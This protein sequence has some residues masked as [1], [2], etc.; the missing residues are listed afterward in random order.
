VKENV[1]CFLA[2]VIHILLLPGGARFF[3]AGSGF[4]TWPAFQGTPERAA[5]AVDFA[6]LESEVAPVIEALARSGIEVVAVHNHMVTEARASSSC[7][8]GA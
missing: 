4:N 1:V 8:T 7:T 2:E 6:M 3:Y 5:V